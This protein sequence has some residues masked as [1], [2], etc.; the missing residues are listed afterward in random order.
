MAAG[1]RSVWRSEDG[2]RSA[3]RIVTGGLRST[4]L[5]AG[6]RSPARFNGLG[7]GACSA[8]TGLEF[9]FRPGELRF[10]PFPRNGIA[11]PPSPELGL[12]ETTLLGGERL[13]P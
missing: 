10:T 5:I 4:C 3:W 11:A 1:L 13:T 8:M 2:L 7:G 6:L 9:K 12:G